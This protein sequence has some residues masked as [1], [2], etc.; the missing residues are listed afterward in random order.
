MKTKST[1]YSR[2]KSV[3]RTAEYLSISRSKLY[4]LVKQG[5]LP[6]VMI[7][8]RRLFDVEDLDQFIEKKKQEQANDVRRC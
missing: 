7:G 1:S 6:C 4:M 5:L 3:E 8:D 2:L